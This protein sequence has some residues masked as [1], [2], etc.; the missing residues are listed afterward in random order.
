MTNQEAII[1]SDVR[2]FEDTINAMCVI[3]NSIDVPEICLA[4]QYLHIYPFLCAKQQ[5]TGTVAEKYEQ[6]TEDI[7]LL[8]I[9]I[10]FVS[11]PPNQP[12]DI[13]SL[14]EQAKQRH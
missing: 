3:T 7:P 10:Y 6:A 13:K 8:Q 12:R 4:C 11:N 2:E 9:C 5:N 14:I 1:K